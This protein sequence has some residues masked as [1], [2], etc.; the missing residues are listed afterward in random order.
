[1]RRFCSLAAGVVAAAALLTLLA[2]P[3]HAAPTPAPTPIAPPPELTAVIDNMAGWLRGFL[4]ALATL[5]LTVGGVR[6]LTANGDPTS[7]EKGKA[8]FKYA[9][10]G[11]AVAALAPILVTALKSVVGR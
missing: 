10:L 5:Y 2:A 8:S 3:A 9:G 1:M 4:A 11:Y 6:Y 7:V